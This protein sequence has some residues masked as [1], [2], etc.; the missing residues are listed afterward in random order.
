MSQ[1]LGSSQRTA[2][3]QGGLALGVMELHEAPREPPYPHA[4][5]IVV[6]SLMMAQVDEWVARRQRVQGVMDQVLART[7]DALEEATRRAR[8]VDPELMELLGQ[9]EFAVLRGIL[10]GRVPPVLHGEEW[11]WMTVVLRAPLRVDPE[12][13]E[14]VDVLRLLGLLDPE[15]QHAVLA[16]VEAARRDA[17]APPEAEQWYGWAYKVLLE[18]PLAFFGAF[19]KAPETWLRERFV[20]EMDWVQALRAR[21]SWRAEDLEP[22][23][24]KLEALGAHAAQRCVGRL[25]AHLRGGPGSR[26]LQ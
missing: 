4:R 25:Q 5:F 1:A 20:G 11:L 23:R 16:R 7:P 9:Y 21:E 17:S 15:V 10:E 3:E 24:R 6:S 13:A 19:A 2:L 14:K 8:E 26:G 18:R 12:E 22:Y